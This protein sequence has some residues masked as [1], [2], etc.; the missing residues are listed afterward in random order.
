MT[1]SSFCLWRCDREHRFLYDCLPEVWADYYTVIYTH[2]EWVDD[3]VS[4]VLH[5]SNAWTIDWLVQVQNLVCTTGHE[6]DL[7][8]AWPTEL[9][10]EISTYCNI[11]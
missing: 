11:C 9:N 1:E 4:E 10:C 2:C 5:G 7:E 3:E 8:I 6:G